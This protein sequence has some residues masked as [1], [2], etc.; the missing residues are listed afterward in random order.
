MRNGRYLPA[1][2]DEQL[3]SWLRTRPDDPD[4]PTSFT[5][6]NLPAL[7]RSGGSTLAYCQSSLLRPTARPKSPPSGQGTLQVTCNTSLV[8]IAVRRLRRLGRRCTRS[9][10]GIPAVHM[11]DAERHTRAARGW[12]A[13][14]GSVARR[15]FIVQLCARYA[16]WLRRSCTLRLSTGLNFFFDP[17]KIH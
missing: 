14:F 17:S 9:I 3:P 8:R 16:P 15:C 4:T 6:R 5:P 1:S 7:G 10:A 11:P 12:C 13:H 2:R